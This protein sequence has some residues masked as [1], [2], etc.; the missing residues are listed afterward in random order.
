[1]K[2]EQCEIADAAQECSCRQVVR[3][4]KVTVCC[5]RLD[6]RMWAIGDVQMAVNRVEADAMR[7]GEFAILLAII[8][9]A[10]P[11]TCPLVCVDIHGCDVY[12]TEMK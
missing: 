1:M 11:Y 2:S 8:G 7:C 3:C 10:A 4:D 12:R 9:P 5:V 6:A